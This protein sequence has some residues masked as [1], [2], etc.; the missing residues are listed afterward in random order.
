[1]GIDKLPHPY[2]IHNKTSSDTFEDDTL[3][4]RQ[5]EPNV[6]YFRLTNEDFQNG[7]KT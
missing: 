6:L 3:I 4:F 2:M 5:K 1:M 7:Y